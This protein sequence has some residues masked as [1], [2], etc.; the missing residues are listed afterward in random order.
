[1]VYRTLK[2]QNGP[3]L[4]RCCSYVACLVK[5]ISCHDAG[6]N[7]KVHVLLWL[8]MSVILSKLVGGIEGMSLRKQH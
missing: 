7:I 2:L 1:M 8:S 6:K 5:K 4:I 3:I